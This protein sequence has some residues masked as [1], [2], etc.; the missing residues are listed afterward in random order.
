M[1]ADDN[2]YIAYEP[3]AGP[4]NSDG[5][6][7]CQAGAADEHCTPSLCEE[8]RERSGKVGEGG[9][10]TLRRGCGSMCSLYCAVLTSEENI[11]PNI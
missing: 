9:H 6:R 5:S 2:G 10:T 11:T 3:P 8:V 7:H 1:V 4:G